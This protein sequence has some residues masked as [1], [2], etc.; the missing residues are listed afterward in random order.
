MFVLWY[1][2]K[3]QIAK[4]VFMENTFQKIERLTRELKE[5]NKTLRKETAP[6][7][8]RIGTPTSAQ[9]IL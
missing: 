9:N 6:V 3:N 7:K 2:N 4:V 8:V 5:A 1:N